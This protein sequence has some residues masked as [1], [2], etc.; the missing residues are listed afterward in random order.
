MESPVVAKA[1]RTCGVPR[2]LQIWTE[3]EFRTLAFKSTEAD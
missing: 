3:R 2:A 1:Q